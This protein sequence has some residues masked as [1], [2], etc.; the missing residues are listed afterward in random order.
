MSKKREELYEILEYELYEFP[1]SITDR[2]KYVGKTP[3]REQ[4]ESVVR[5]AEAE[6]K[7]IFIKAACSDGVKRF[8][9]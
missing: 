9:Y 6:G 5:N 8:Y 1:R 4:A 2:G 3:L 7:Q